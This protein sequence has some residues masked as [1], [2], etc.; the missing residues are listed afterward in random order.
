LKRQ[1]NGEGSQGQLSKDESNQLFLSPNVKKESG[2]LKVQNKT[3]D[4]DMRV[5]A[6]PMRSQNDVYIRKARRARN[7]ANTKGFKNMKGDGLLKNGRRGRNFIG[8]Q[9]AQGMGGLMS[10][11]Q[12]DISSQLKSAIE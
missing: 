8:G 6:A 3:D 10:Q 2:K 1:G 7:A 4:Q 11:T 5:I 12:Q 9:G